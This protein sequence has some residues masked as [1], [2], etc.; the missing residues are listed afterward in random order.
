LNHEVR[1]DTVENHIV[2]VSSFGEC[3]KILA[4]L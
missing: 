1:D 2:V 4:C 3:R